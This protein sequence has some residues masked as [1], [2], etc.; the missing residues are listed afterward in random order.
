[1]VNYIYGL[2]GR[3]V[4]PTDLEG[5]FKEILKIAKTGEVKDRLRFLGVK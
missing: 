5:V 2:G 1:M 4:T 3:D